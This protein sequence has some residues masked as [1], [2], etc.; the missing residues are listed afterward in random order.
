MNTSNFNIK[1]RRPGLGHYNGTRNEW[2]I[3]YNMARVRKSKGLPVDASHGGLYW[4][5]QLIIYNEREAESFSTLK[6]ADRYANI[7]FINE[8]LDNLEANE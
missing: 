8:L 4:K 2:K 6:T 1:Q 7:K 5:A 3:A